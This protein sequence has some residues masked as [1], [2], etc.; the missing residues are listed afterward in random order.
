MHYVDDLSVAMRDAKA[1]AGD[2]NVLVHGAGIAQ[3]A[4]T[5]GGGMVHLRYRLH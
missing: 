2:R 3:R 4:I 1:A 5:T